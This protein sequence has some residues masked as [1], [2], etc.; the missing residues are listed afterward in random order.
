[1]EKRINNR[2]L[3]QRLTQKRKEPAKDVKRKTIACKTREYLNMVSRKTIE[4]EN[5]VGQAAKL[6]RTGEREKL[7]IEER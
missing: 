3:K 4:F 5:V 2:I 1:M 6:Q 7:S